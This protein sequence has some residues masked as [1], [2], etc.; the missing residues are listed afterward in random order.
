MTD[1]K[2]YGV[3]IQA[4]NNSSRL[5]SKMSKPFY[6]QKSILEILISELIKGLE[7]L[8]VIL[9]TTENESD[10]ALASAVTKFNIPVFR[11]EENNVLQRMTN[12]A[13]KNDIT[14]IIRI[15]SDN[16][17]LD[18]ESIA[19]LIAYHKSNPTDYVSYEVGNNKPA[20]LS[21]F[22]FYAELVTIDALHRVNS[23]TDDPKYLEHVTNY[24]Y[25]HADEFIL[26][27]LKAPS[28]VY[29]RADLRLTVDTPQDFKLAK[30]LYANKI[31]NNWNQRELIN[32]IDSNSD[33]KKSMIKMINTNTK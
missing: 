20:I 16:P 26:N 29:N 7:N 10:N 2:S 8:P 31:K 18:I 28:Y 24:I 19:K 5:K 3:I 9:A 32:F 23:S 11:G 30:Y 33:I 6:D 27:F 12:A 13:V 17:F 15:C 14:N 1:K 22:G 25:T 21:H 4:R